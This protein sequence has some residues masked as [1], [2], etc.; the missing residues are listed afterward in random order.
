[1]S[2]AGFRPPRKVTLVEAVVEQ[3]A[4]Q[5]QSGKLKPGERLP[6]ERKLIDTMQVGRSSVREALQGLAMMG[7]VEIRPGQGTFVSRGARVLVPE[8]GRADLSAGLRREMRLSLCDARRFIESETA[9]RAAIHA[10]DVSIAHLGSILETY[11][12]LARQTHDLE[13]ANVPHHSFHIEIARMSENAFFAPMLDMLLHS[14]PQSLRRGELVGFESTPVDEI[15]DE[16]LAIHRR[17]FDA[18]ASHDP[19][20]AALAMDRHMAFEERLINLA[21]E[22]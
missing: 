15:F 13:A 6:S 1:M 10:D 19:D 9:K 16:E 7:L 11:C 20:A 8:V 5:I 12:L 17:I 21:F 14:V 4:D 2:E 18:I 22:S 3:I